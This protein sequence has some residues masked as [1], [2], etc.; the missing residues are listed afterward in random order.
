MASPDAFPSTL[1]FRFPEWQLEYEAAL[2]ELD[3]E[4]LPKRVA[5]AETAIF[6]RLEALVGKADHEQERIAMD[7]ALHALRLLKQGS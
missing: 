2:L 5:T 6:T 1:L 4:K 3:R 7:D